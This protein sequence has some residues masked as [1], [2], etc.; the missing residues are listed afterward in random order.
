[1]DNQ[2]Q[3]ILENT[4]VI[5]REPQAGDFVAGVETGIIYEDRLK[6]KKWID[7]ALPDTDGDYQWAYIS[8]KYNFDGSTCTNYGCKHSCEDQ[9]NWLLVNNKFSAK[10]L[11]KLYSYKFIYAGKATRLSAR[12]NAI[13]SGTNGGQ[14]AGQFLGNYLY[15]PWDSARNIG[16]VPELLCPFDRTRKDWTTE[17]YFDSACIT[18]EAEEVAKVFKEIFDVRYEIVFTTARDMQKHSQQS[19]LTI[20]AGVCRP[21]GARVA[22]CDLNSGHCTVLLELPNVPG[23]YQDQDSYWPAF[24]CLESGYKISYAI[25]GVLTPRSQIK[26]VILATQPP[27]KWTMKMKKGDRGSEIVRL[28]DVLKI[29]GFFPKY[30]TST[31]YYGLVT[32][33][34]VLKFQLKYQLDTPANL[35]SWKGENVASRTLNQLNKLTF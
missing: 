25:K 28:Q 27:H 16:M 14:I 34:A 19:P 7:F 20:S 31:G 1:M 15:K 5:A 26:P 33:G 32:C 24:K 18:S 8:P 23:D 29:W 35:N 21:W 12:F 3:I 17:K 6:G 10:E 9:I 30:T 13:K 11:E 22:K 2:N 4:G